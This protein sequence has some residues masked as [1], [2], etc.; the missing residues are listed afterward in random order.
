MSAEDVQTITTLIE[1]NPHMNRAALSR[2]LCELW[3]WRKP[4]GELKDMT[5]RVALLRM[6]A[7]GLIVLP[8]SRMASGR[9]RPSFAPH[10]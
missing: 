8:P 4:N 1:R 3:H 2:L 6:A 7:D 9:R 10:Q 5:C